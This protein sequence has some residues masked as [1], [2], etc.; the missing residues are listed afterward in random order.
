MH[1]RCGKGD[2]WHLAGSTKNPSFVVI[3]TN[4]V[5][6]NRSDGEQLVMGAGLARQAS[7][8]YPNLKYDIVTRYKQHAYLGDY[9]WSKLVHIFSEGI[10]VFPTKKHWKNP[11]S[12]SLIVSC[13]KELRQEMNTNPLLRDSYVLVPQIG[14]GLGGL[15]WEKTVKPE[16]IKYLVEGMQQSPVHTIALIE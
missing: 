14:C 2:V 8:R 10:I 3:P 13:L 9:Q 16:V 5:I 1:A 11:S 12:L 6:T 4:L 7:E 15:N